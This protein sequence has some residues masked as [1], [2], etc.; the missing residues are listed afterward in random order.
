VRGYTAKK[1]NRYYAVIYEGVDPATGKERRR[2]YPAGTRKAEA[3]KLVTAL[4]KRRNDG[5][6]RA[7]EKITLGAYLTNKWLP[8]QRAQ[9]RPSTLDSYERN[10]RLHVIPRLGNVALQQLAPED[11]DGFYG[12]LLASGR[13]EG[14][15]GLSNKTVR[16]VHGILHKALAD[17]QRKGT[18]LRNVAALADA[19]KLSSSKKRE[20]RVWN[21]GELRAFLLGV[22]DE[23][24]HAAFFLA[25]HTGMRRGEVLGLR[26]A[27]VDLDKARLSVRQAIIS[28]AY[29]VKVSDVKTGTGRRT[30]NLDTRTVGVL[31]AWRKAALA[32][33]MLVGPAFADNDLVFPRPDGT[34]T[35]PDAFSQAFDRAVVRLGLPIISLH[36][37]RHTHATL[38]LRA[39]VPVKV[40]SERLG[41]ASPAFTLTVYQHVIPGMQEEAASLFSELIFGADEP[42]VAPVN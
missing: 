39:G 34:P 1:G 42:A 2:W 20:A 6:Y 27:D 13:R 32:E 30:I 26:W 28:V 35:H 37:L 12:E 15:G 38:L 31:R 36:D 19:P 10:I 5:D 41:H 7:P 24:A 3:D 25:A 22:G 29:Q 40:V 4:V 33:R 23:R 16:Y 17:A 21:A 9:L 18:V 11:L 8:A 14:G